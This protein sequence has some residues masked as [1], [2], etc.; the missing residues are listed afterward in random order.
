MGPMILQVLQQNHG[1]FRLNPI[2][3]GRQTNQ[4]WCFFGHPMA[5]HGGKVSSKSAALNSFLGHHLVGG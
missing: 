4:P 3:R 1:L 2:L 5:S